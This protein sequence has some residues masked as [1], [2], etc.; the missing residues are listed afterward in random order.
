MSGTK[1]ITPADAGILL[2]AGAAGVLISAAC[3]GG[4]AQLMVAQG[5][6][7][8]IAP[9]AATA[10]V[11]LGSFFSGGVAAFCKKSRGLLTGLLQGMMLAGLL[12]LLSLFFGNTL[13]AAQGVRMAV[14]TLS[15]GSGG[16]VGITLA[17]KLR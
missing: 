14:V 17:E 5:V 15:G 9:F 2:L 16:L 7:P 1:L 13:T 6:S 3:L 12:L 10:S 11:G 8:S 4:M